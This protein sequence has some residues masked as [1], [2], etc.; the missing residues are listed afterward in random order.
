[1]E[2]ISKQSY[3]GT[4]LVAK[5]V[6][7]RSKK[8]DSIRFDSTDGGKITLRPSKHNQSTKQL[9]IFLIPSELLH[10]I[11]Q[12]GEHGENISERFT[13]ELRHIKQSKMVSDAEG[14]LNAL[15]GNLGLTTIKNVD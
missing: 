9:G 4:S 12:K 1:M 2:S 6:Q 3:T 8:E 15:F 7:I 14:G 5:F 11:T 10:V 13:G